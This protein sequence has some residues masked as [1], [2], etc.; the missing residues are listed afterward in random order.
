MA[1]MDI[2]IIAVTFFLIT[3]FL[4]LFNVVYDGAR[5]LE[6]ENKRLKERIKKLEEQQSELQEQQFK[7]Q[8]ESWKR[9]L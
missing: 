1:T 5:Y 2:A 7:L 8:R 3:I 9:Y 6:E 4:Y